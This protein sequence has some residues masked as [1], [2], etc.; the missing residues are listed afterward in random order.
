MKNKSKF[1]PELKAMIEKDLLLCEETILTPNKTHSLYRQLTAKYVPIYPHICDGIPC[2]AKQLDSDWVEELKMFKGTL[3]I[4]LATQQ[5]PQETSQPQV[6]INIKKS[7]NSG[8]IGTDN[9]LTKST[10]VGVDLSVPIQPKVKI[11]KGR[12]NNG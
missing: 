12:K 1:T 8:N 7:K 2:I 4:I 11:L 9:Q 10:E 5:E 3:E 6:N